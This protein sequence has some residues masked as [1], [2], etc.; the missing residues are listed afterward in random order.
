[1]KG[2]D[3]GIFYNTYKDEKFNTKE[4]E[5]ETEKLIPDDD[6]IKKEWYLFLYF[7]S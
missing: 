7:N 3:W 6:V 4:I 5:E 1:M 2:V